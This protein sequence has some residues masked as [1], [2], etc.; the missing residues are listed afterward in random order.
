MQLCDLTNPNDSSQWN[1]Q[2][3]L[4]LLGFMLF[5]HEP[6]ARRRFV[7]RGKPF[8]AGEPLSDES[9]EDK[10]FEQ[11]FHARHGKGSQAGQIFLTLIQL[12]SNDKRPSLE[13]AIQRQQLLLDP[14]EGHK[15]GHFRPLGH[16]GQLTHN[17]LKLQAISREYRSVIHFWAAHIHALQV[18]EH[19]LP[20][21]VSPPAS[22]EEALSKFINCSEAFWQLFV[23]TRRP[24][25][26][27]R[28]IIR[29]QYRLR[30]KVPVGYRV[31]PRLVARKLETISPRK[32]VINLG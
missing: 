25:T 5:P 19:P 20:N 30:V 12:A 2:A 24:A 8:F 13:K 26:N 1:D 6:D 10:L 16:I 3:E 7:R 14:Y 18:A 23:Q 28:P 15:P 31:L 22:R 11:E 4:K 9:R 29:E 27:G 17:R 32:S 21:D